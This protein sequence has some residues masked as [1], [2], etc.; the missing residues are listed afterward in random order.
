MF[1]V[2]EFTKLKKYLRNFI[3]GIII[4]ASMM[5]PGFSG[6]TAAIILGVFYEIIN[7][8][9]KLLTEFKKSVK[10]LLPFAVGGITGIFLVCFPLNYLFTKYQI[11][12]SYFIIG[13]IFGSIGC[14]LPSNKIKFKSIIWV[15]I[16]AIPV[17]ISQISSTNIMFVN[18]YFLLVIVGFLSS[19]ALILPG[20]SLTN[21]LISFGCYEELIKAIIDFNLLYIFV[22]SMSMIVGVL[23]LIKTIIKLYSKYTEITNLILLGM[24]LCSISQIY[25]SFSDYRQ[26]I[27]CISLLLGGTALSLYLSRFEK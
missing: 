16:G 18:N 21:I 26:I 5:I 24:I 14:F 6:G 25:T 10:R 3:Y 7:S 17:V 19:I 15:V 12:F 13:I 11:Y 20:I 23:L 9:S 22:Y 1:F 2:I 27:P 8:A 4:G